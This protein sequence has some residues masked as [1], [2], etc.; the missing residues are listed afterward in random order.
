MNNELVRLQDEERAE[1]ARILAE[2]T[3]LIQASA[4][5]IE[6]ARSLSAY[7]ELVFAK[8]RFGREFD[9]VRPTFLARFVAQ[10]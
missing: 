8:A 6:S 10:P 3:D 7:L 9:C 5:Q 2:L 4:G 1:I